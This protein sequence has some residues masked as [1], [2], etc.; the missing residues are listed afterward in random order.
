MG[1]NFDAKYCNS[2]DKIGNATKERYEGII[3]HENYREV[4][5]DF[6]YYFNQNDINDKHNTKDC[7]KFYNPHLNINDNLSQMRSSIGSSNSI[8]MGSTISSLNS[9]ANINNNNNSNTNN[10]NNNNSNYANSN[11]SNNNNYN[12]FNNSNSVNNGFSPNIQRSINEKINILNNIENKFSKI[13]IL[14]SSSSASRSVI[15]HYR[16]ASTSNLSVN[17]ASTSN[18]SNV[19]NNNSSGVNSGNNI[20][21]RSG[22]TSNFQY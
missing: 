9:Y 20:H 22:S 18:T 8:N 4:F 15:K 3:R 21:R 19:N 16:H 12:N 17:N 1:D 7:K 10:Y 2:L 11:I 6:F 5:H 14:S 13:K